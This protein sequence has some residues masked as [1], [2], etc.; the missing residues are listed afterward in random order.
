MSSSKTKTPSLGL[1]ILILAAVAA[2]IAATVLV[3]QVDIHITLIM[4]AILAGIVGITVLKYDYETIEKGIVD[5]IMTGMQACLILYTVGPLVGTWIAS[6]V[7][8]SMIYYG[9]SILSPSIFLFATLFICSVVSLATGTSWGT[10]GTVGIALMGIALGL[11]VP[12]P[13]TAGIII[14][15]AYFGDKMSPLSDTTN[16][17]PAVAGT[18]LFQHI[19]AMTWTTGPTYVIVAAITIIIGF[20]YA[21]GHLDT[22]KIEALQMLMKAEFWISP[23]AFLAPAVVIVLSAMR[24][25]ALPSL[26]AGILVAVVF[27]VIN[28]VGVGEILNIMQNG[29]TPTISAQL[30]DSAEDAAAV[31]KIMAENG[32]TMDPKIMLE[33]AKDIVELMARGGLQSMN[34]TISLI[35][36]AFTF[37]STM[38]VCGFLKVIL[39]AIMKPIRSVGGMVAATIMSCFVCDLFLGDQYL[40]IAMPGRM[41]KSAYDEKGLHPRMLSR[42]LEDAGTLV[43]VLIPWNTCGAYHTQVL[44][45]PTFSYL[46][47]A[48]LNYLNP[49]IAIIMTY[50]GIGIFWRGK[51]GEPVHGGKTRPANLA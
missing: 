25:P 47:Y 15:G 20:R 28:G 23:I 48:F 9:L 27:A 16:L 38:E 46:P 30:A 3:W 32:L 51:D 35:L 29:Y 7:V 44:G 10:S 36:C 22:Q 39:E 17:A 5:G 12:A 1:A 40:S 14:S 43:S 6:G 21:G 33:A 45:V 11:G 8:P 31:A 49:I 4:G 42:C 24:K 34:W 13:L 50:M 26:Y 18:D 2:M 41:F 19:R 37:G